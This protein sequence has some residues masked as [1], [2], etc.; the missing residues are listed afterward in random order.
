M[1]KVLVGFQGFIH[2]IE[3]PGDEYP[4]YNGPDA[5]F[6]WVNAPDEVTLDWTLEYSP[7]QERSIWVERERPAADKEVARK[8]AYGTIEAQLDMIYHELQDTGSL[9]ATGPWASHITLVKNTL[10]APEASVTAMSPEEQM[11]VMAVMEPSADELPKL[12]TENDPPWIHSDD[13]PGMEGQP[14]DVQPGEEA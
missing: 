3:N 8:V 9:S 7:A 13:W 12:S 4:I 11:A 2:Q 10:D 6:T 5:K 14:V 1:K